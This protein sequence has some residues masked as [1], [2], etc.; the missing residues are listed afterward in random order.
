[1]KVEISY[2]I[3][4]FYMNHINFILVQAPHA[5]TRFFKDP[6][7]IFVLTTINFS[8]TPPTSNTLLIGSFNLK[9]TRGDSLL[10]EFD[11]LL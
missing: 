6:E 11:F 10:Q 3:P 4:Y 1:M 5:L 8:P 9:R 7:E 2:K